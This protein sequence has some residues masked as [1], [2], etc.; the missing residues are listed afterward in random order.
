MVDKLA[1]QRGRRL[2]RQRAA[3]IEPVFAQTKHNRGFRSF[4]RRGLVAADSE[5]KLIAATHNLLKLWR[6]PVIT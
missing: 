1:T 4:S 2:Y 6:Q 3:A 5:W